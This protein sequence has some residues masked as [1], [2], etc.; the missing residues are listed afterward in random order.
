MKNYNEVGR[1]EREVTERERNPEENFGES[2]F[3][4]QRVHLFPFRT[5]KLSSAVPKILSWRRLGK[6]GQCRHNIGKFERETFQICLLVRKRKSEKIRYFRANGRNRGHEWTV[7]DVRSRFL[8]ELPG[9]DFK[10]PFGWDLK[11]FGGLQKHRG[12]NFDCCLSVGYLFIRF[13]LR[14]GSLYIPP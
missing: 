7:R 5:Q 9:I 13:E 1:L 6:I 2:V 8:I 3:L 10:M 14:F 11:T 12:E 4:T